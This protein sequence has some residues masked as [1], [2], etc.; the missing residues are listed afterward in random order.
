MKTFTGIPVSEGIAVGK[1]FVYAENVSPEIPTY[2]ISEGEV[3]AEW[4]R[5]QKA[6]AK[7]ADEIK[8]LLEDAAGKTSGPRCKEQA[9]IFQAHLFMLEDAEFIEEIRAK[10]KQSLRNVEWVVQ[11]M[12]RELCQKLMQVPDQSFR[13]RA[14]DI[15]DVARRVIDCLLC[16]AHGSSSLANL[17]EGTIL[18]ARD[19][20]PSDTLVLDKS[21]VRGIALE[22]GGKTSHTAIL[23]RAF[24]IP[25][26]LGLSGISAE[27]RNGETLVLNGKSGVV[28]VNPD[29][30]TLE[31]QESEKKLEGKRADRFSAL[32][33]LPA[34]TRDGHR[35]A[36]LA[37][38]GFPEEAETLFQHGAQGIGLYRSEFLF[39][40]P[41][42]TA[43]EETQ[44]EAY[45]R[46]LKAMGEK[47]VTIRTMDVGGDKI[48]NDNFAG[49]QALDE[50]NP[51]LGCRAIRLS[52]ANPELFKTQLRAML[53]ASVHGNLKIMFP[54][55]CCVEEV[56]QARALLDEAR[57]ECKKR[58]QPFAE[59]IEVGIM[60]EVPAAAISADILAEKSDFFSVG[61]NDLIQ[62]SLAADRGNEK[63][64]Y[65]SDSHH[66]AVLRLIK[67]TID[68]AH[69]RGIKACVCGE[70]A[71][72]PL[73]T[74]IL[75]GL[76]LDE[77]SMNAPSIPKIK[78]IIRG[79]DLESCRKLA[80]ETLRGHSVAE[81]RASVNAW[82]SENFP[83]HE[84]LERRAQ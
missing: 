8:A 37:N 72:D 50:K 24:G 61:T 55:I 18:V 36:L 80:A 46:A 79:T 81:V 32:K 19:L 63:V 64:H 42:K 28:I 7:A 51:L 67:R 57:A 49:L 65:L 34:Q 21:R 4:E 60:I 41:G 6:I 48:A 3:P 12:S 45:A 70:L 23:A 38:I 9:D 74:A 15:A 53:R 17:D 10:L 47:P 68:A 83:G 78:E 40:E 76:G 43:G 54:L 39:I 26:V 69:E 66:P 30:E 5:L 52:L 71:G 27:L 1:A 35:V 56:E 16:V 33:E 77:F 2:A 20:M 13:E 44:Y 82:M 62:Y 84:S 73:A 31:R 75:L 59:N 22:E 14:A 25:A 29:R 58:N 11:D